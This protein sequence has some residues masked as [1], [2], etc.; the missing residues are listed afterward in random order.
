[1]HQ[2]KN[3][4]GRFYV[5]DVTLLSH[6][7]HYGAAVL[8]F[9]FTPKPHTTTHF[10]LPYLVKGTPNDNGLIL[11]T[12]YHWCLW[13][14]AQAS[15]VNRP[16]KLCLGKLFPWYRWSSSSTPTG[17]FLLIHRFWER[18][19]EMPTLIA[20]ISRRMVIGPIGT[21]AKRDEGTV[22]CGIKLL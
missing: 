22:C 12:R 15:R 4:A 18:T 19:W 9:A 10:K 2:T 11:A 6:F 1:M 3:L 13:T 20:T 16:T 5:Y 14:L 21:H 8:L 7:L 17:L